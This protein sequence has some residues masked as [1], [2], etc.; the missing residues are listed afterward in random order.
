MQTLKKLNLLGGKVVEKSTS[1]KSWIPKRS[2]FLDTYR[3]S[4]IH[5]IYISETK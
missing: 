2:G 3:K 1:I 4:W 5:I